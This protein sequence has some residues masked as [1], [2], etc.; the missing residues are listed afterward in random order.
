MS[1]IKLLKFTLNTEMLRG[2]NAALI[3]NRTKFCT[4]Y[5]IFSLRYFLF[6]IFFM[7]FDV[8]DFLEYFFSA[9]LFLPWGT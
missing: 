3:K 4:I 5:G 2:E 1:N 8:G 6:F 9:R 7:I